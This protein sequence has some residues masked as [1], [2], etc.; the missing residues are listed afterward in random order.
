[1][2]ASRGVARCQ[3]WHLDHIS[4]H[5]AQVAE[6]IVTRLAKS[7]RGVVRQQA[8]GLAVWH[9]CRLCLYLQVQSQG[10]HVLK[11]LIMHSCYRLALVTLLLNVNL[12]GRSAVVSMR[13]CVCVC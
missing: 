3:V 8:G 5:N 12:W 7:S 2:R 10:V 4:Q 13:A 9:S 1:M 6:I 11:Q